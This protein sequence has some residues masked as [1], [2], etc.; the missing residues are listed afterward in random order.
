M[1][2]SVNYDSTL[3]IR[4]DGK[5]RSRRDNRGKP[6][7]GCADSQRQD[8]ERRSLSLTALA[9]DF[10]GAAERDIRPIDRTD[11]G[12]RHGQNSW[13]STRLAA[14]DMSHLSTHGRSRCDQH[15]A[16]L[17]VIGGQMKCHLFALVDRCTR[18]ILIDCHG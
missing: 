11:G 4:E 2:L 10:C 9:A 17:R 5:R 15:V 8:A 18:K 3:R 14:V 12:Y 6:L 1:G 7:L 16:E 13:M